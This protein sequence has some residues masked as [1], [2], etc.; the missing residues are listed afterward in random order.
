MFTL[1]DDRL[2]DA[3]L[4]AH[5]RG[6]VIGLPEKQFYGTAIPAAVLV[7]RQRKSDDSVLFVDASRDYED[8]KNQNY[9][10]ETD[11]QRILDTVQARRNVDKYAYLASP[12]EI[13]NND[14]NLNIPRYVDTFEEEAEI[15][16]MAVRREREQLKAE[17][18]RL[19]EQMAKYL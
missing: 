13:A 2:T 9:L 5:Q 14:F 6:V 1:A 16:L 15:D 11:L 10:R 17:L 3:V 7:F 19:E 4:Q 12:V 8:G 18:A